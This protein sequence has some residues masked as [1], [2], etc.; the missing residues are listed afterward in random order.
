[1]RL[2]VAC[3]LT[4]L[5]AC[6]STSTE[7]SPRDVT[8]VY[9]ASELLVGAQDNPRDA[10]VRGGRMTMALQPD[11]TFLATVDLPAPWGPFWGDTAGYVAILTGSYEEA[12]AGDSLS[13]L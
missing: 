13:L 1:M 12:T 6:T 10:L 4:P 2:L 9:A 3:G 11:Q 7:T 8:G 5:L